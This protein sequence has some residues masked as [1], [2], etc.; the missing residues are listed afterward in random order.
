MNIFEKLMNIQCKIKAPKNLYNSYGKYNYRNCE[1]I[2]EAVKPFLE[3][4]KCALILNDDIVDGYVKSTVTLINAEKPN[5]VVVSQAFARESD[6]KGMSADQCTGAA[7]SYARKYALNAL[8]LLDDTK[9]SDT[10]EVAQISKR[11]ASKKAQSLKCEKC[12]KE[13]TVP[14]GW[15]VTQMREYFKQKNEGH[16]ECSNCRKVK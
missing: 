5:E 4:E 7:S 2:L 15:T 3:T 13:I 6:H 1:S 8:F 9:D 14:E 16:V 11:S 12:G 10:D